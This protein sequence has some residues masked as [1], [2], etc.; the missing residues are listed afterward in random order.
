MENFIPCQ[1]VIKFEESWCPSILCCKAWIDKEYKVTGTN[2]DVN[3]VPK[4]GAD[5]LFDVIDSKLLK[6]VSASKSE[7]GDSLKAVK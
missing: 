7:D 2:V 5:L 4:V 1:V 6:C 3:V